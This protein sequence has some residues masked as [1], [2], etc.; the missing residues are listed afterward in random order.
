M[1]SLEELCAEVDRCE[2]VVGKYGAKHWG[3][4]EASGE[5]RVPN[6]PKKRFEKENIDAVRNHDIHILCY[7]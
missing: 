5:F 4:T 2:T 6:K 7:L 1:T 3:I